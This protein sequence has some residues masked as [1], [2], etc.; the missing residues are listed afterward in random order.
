MKS[1]IIFSLFILLSTSC[2]SKK[3][4][5]PTES[6][7]PQIILSHGGGFTGEVK[8]FYLLENGQLFKS[9]DIAGTIC[10][11]KEL[12]TNFSKQIFSNYKT[13]GINKMSRDTPG[14]MVYSITMKDK[15][16]EHKIEWG[17]GQEGTEML[18]VFYSNVMNM[19]RIS[20]EDKK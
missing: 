14:N 5:D 11:Q 16:G 10:S 6:D 9:D 12:K 13:L 15:N 7:E 20:N 8:T 17:R 3:V 18:Q 1:S 4:I 2:G 19:I